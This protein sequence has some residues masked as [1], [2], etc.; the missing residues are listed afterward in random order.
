MFNIFKRRTGTINAIT[1]PDLGWSVEDD[2][3]TRKVWVNQ[4]RS[5][6]LSLNLF[7]QKP[8][9]PT[10]K[11]LIELRNYYRQQIASVK[12]GLIEVNKIQTHGIEAIKTIF[13]IPQD[14]NGMT[15]LTSVTIP[16]KFC[17]YV[18]KIEAPEIGATGLR[19]TVIADQ[20]LE[21]GKIT[22]GDQGFE[23]WFNDPYN[24]KLTE[25]TL[26]NKSEN[27]QY[28]MLFPNHPLSKSRTLFKTLETQIQFDDTVINLPKF[29]K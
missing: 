25:G 19:D 24:L 16:F 23:D 5:M 12:G 27:E 7:N 1:I 4:E 21:K 10:M 29:N 14:P 3:T 18:I 15:Y 17:S 26:M 9:L 22:I 11:N 13:K 28:D 2:T 6:V 8:D 20:L